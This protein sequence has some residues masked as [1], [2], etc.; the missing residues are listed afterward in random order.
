[1][2]K[3]KHFLKS[4]T[5]WKITQNLNLFLPLWKSFCEL[6]SQF[7]APFPP[8]PNPPHLSPDYGV[9]M[10]TMERIMTLLWGWIDHL[11]TTFRNFPIINDLYSYI[12]VYIDNYRNNYY[13]PY[14]IQGLDFLS[15]QITWYVS[16]VLQQC[17]QRWW[18][19]QLFQMS[20]NN[21]GSMPLDH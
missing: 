15:F 12:H 16:H 5:F 18:L 3:A 7:P 9:Q 4:Q 10:K 19:C 6:G 8:L 11:A 14:S 17:N 21:L 20:L 1:M 2:R 13:V